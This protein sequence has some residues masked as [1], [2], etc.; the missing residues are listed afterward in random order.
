MGEENIRKDSGTAA[1]Q[2]MWIMRTNEEVGE[3]YKDLNVVTDIKKKRLEW[4]G[5]AVR[6]EQVKTQENI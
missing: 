4:I 1:E 6:M 3:L 5:H 2:G